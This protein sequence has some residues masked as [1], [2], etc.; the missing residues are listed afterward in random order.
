MKLFV[1]VRKQKQIQRIVWEDIEA[2]F[3]IPRFRYLTKR[4]NPESVILFSSCE[5]KFQKNRKV[6]NNFTE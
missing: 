5:E 6:G 2:R 3:F 4:N 1:F